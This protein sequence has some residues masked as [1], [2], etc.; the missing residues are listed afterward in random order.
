VNPIILGSSFEILFLAGFIPFL[1]G[2][3]EDLFKN[4]STSARLVATGL[5]PIVFIALSGTYLNHLDIPVIDTW[6]A[7]APVGMVFSVFAVS[8]M[9]N[10]INIIDGF[11]GLAIGVVILILLA[12]SYVA[13]G[14]QDT[15]LF[16]LLIL[17]A[18]VSAGFMLLN[19]PFGKIFMGDGGAYFLGFMVGQIA[20]LL[21]MR[22]PELSPW[23][24]LLICAYPVVEVLYSVYRRAF[25][26]MSSGQPDD[27][28]LHT[29]IKIKLIRVHFPNLPQYQ[30]SA[31]VA[32]LIWV[33]VAALGAVACVFGDNL[34]VL[35]I[36]FSLF[37][38]AYHFTYLWLVDRKTLPTEVESGN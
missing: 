28:H 31:L 34:P 12:F 10:S 6:M 4:V 36:S 21:P 15:D 19:Y 3:M 32:P 1:Y 37:V 35:V 29:L 27:E 30:R 11:N 25:K 38:L 24:S 8:G 20:I 16:N 23:V 13:Y 33:M 2:F 18:A 22:N 26:K 7:W 5:G 17:L 9:T 14:T